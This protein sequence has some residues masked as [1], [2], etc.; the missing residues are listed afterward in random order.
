M[1]RPSPSN[2]PVFAEFKLSGD[3]FQFEK[4]MSW[5]SVFLLKLQQS[6]PIKQIVL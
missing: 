6:K 2:M 4:W 5:A 3:I 1:K